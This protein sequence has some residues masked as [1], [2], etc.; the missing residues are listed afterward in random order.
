MSFFL[1]G[2]GHKDN[3]EQIQIYQHRRVVFGIITSPFLLTATLEYHLNRVAENLKQTAMILKNFFYIDNC[4]ASLRSVEV[5][6]KFVLESQ[7]I[8]IY[9]DS[10]KICQTEW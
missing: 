3:F 10:N 2:G 8:L 7:F 4:V 5:V 9:V 6:E 1:G